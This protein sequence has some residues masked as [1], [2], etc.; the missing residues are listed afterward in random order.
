[1]PH[2]R[3]LVLLPDTDLYLA[4]LNLSCIDIVNDPVSVKLPPSGHPSAE[5]KALFPDMDEYIATL[6][7]S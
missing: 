4:G 7:L 1:M 3:V 6:K 2:R 5:Y